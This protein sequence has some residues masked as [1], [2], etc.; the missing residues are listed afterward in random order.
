MK[1]DPEC[2]ERP[3]CTLK[4]FEHER[5]VPEVCLRIFRKKAK[6]DNNR[7]VCGIRPFNRIRKRRV[8]FRPVGGLHPVQ[9]IVFRAQRCL[10]D[11]PDP[12]RIDPALHNPVFVWFG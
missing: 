5:K 3:G 8:F 12:V 4:T 10:T 6:V 2:F 11:N 1:P 7:E 9:D